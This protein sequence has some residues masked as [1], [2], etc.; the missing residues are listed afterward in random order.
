MGSAWLTSAVA[1]ADAALSGLGLQE[2]VTHEAFNGQD[3]Y[4][5]P[6]A[7]DAPILRAAL[8]QRKQGLIA[9]AGGQ[10]IQYKAAIC[11]VGEVAVDAQDRITLSDGITGPLFVPHG[12][13]VNPAT[14]ELFM[15]T[16][17]LR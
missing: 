9:T 17:Y 13:M 3:A 6:A 14:G 10:E 8:V 4:G 15:R 11:F 5:T 2:D 1:A 12:G 16:V 7:Y